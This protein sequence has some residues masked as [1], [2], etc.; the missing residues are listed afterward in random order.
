MIE[1][2]HADLVALAKSFGLFYFIA[3]SCIIVAYVYW[4]SNKEKFER[5]GES[6]ITDEDR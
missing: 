3:M 1:F 4:P 5:M 6:I 2:D